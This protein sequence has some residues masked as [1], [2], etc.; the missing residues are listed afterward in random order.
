MFSIIAS[1]IILW[2]GS[3]SVLLLN[4]GNYPMAYQSLFFAFL[5]AIIISL[6]G[7]KISYYAKTADEGE[8]GKAEVGLKVQE[9]K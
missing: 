9:S 1:G 3:K 5:G 7:V 4:E 2:G 6:M 8:K